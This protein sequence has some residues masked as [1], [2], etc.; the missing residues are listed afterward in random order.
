MTDDPDFFP[1]SNLPAARPV[2]PDTGRR[3]KIVT[4]YVHDDPDEGYF[5]D[6]KDQLGWP[7]D[8]IRW[9]VL[10]KPAYEVGL[11]LEVD[12]DSGYTRIV[13]IGGVKLATLAE[14]A[15]G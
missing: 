8:D 5:H 12:L 6:F 15:H 9:E 1:L 13:G 3:T 14:R 11:D 7:E 10:G 2:V 4:L